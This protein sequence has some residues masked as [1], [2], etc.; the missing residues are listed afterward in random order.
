MPDPSVITLTDRDSG[1]FF[2]RGVLGSAGR[3]VFYVHTFDPAEATRAPGIPQ[4]GTPWSEDDD[5]VLC[6]DV[7]GGVVSGKK[8]APNGI[9]VSGWCKVTAEY[10]TPAL[11]AGGEI[12]PTAR[13]PGNRFTRYYASDGQTEVFEDISGIPI[14]E[15]RG[16][17]VESATLEVRVFDYRAED[18]DPTLYLGLLSPPK[19]NSSPVTLPPQYGQ[20]AARV[21]PAG[22]LLFRPPIVTPVTEG[23][24]EVQWRMAAAIDH[25]FRWRK[26]NAD[27]TPSGPIILSTV[28]ESASFAGVFS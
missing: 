4:A 18:P 17:R 2:R 3:R 6:F 24:V 13:I 26:H 25:K 22:Q 16:A 28:Y 8:L 15:G 1:Y 19:V 10:G 7:V 5:D 14:A 12:P 23:I 27:G 21:M 11:A 20:S 9:D